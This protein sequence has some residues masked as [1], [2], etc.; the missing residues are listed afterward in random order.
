MASAHGAK[1]SKETAMKNPFDW[2]FR[3][4]LMVLGASIALNIAVC[5]LSQIWPWVI[6]IGL[7]VTVVFFAIRIGK[8]RRRK[9]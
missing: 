6:G 8:E 4:A 9:W 3:A 7:L 2:F 1:D 5:L